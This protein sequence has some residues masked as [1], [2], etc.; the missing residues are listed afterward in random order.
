MG[1]DKDIRTERESLPPRQKRERERERERVNI[2]IRGIGIR[3]I[4]G[5]MTRHHA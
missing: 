5:E 3:G 2:Y 1:Y 4:R